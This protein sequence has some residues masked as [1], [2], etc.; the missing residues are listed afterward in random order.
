MRYLFS[1]IVF[2]A[3]LMAGHGQQL[4]GEYSLP[5]TNGQITLT[6]QGTQNITGT[7]VDDNGA[8]YQ[9]QGTESQGK[10]TGG[11]A[12]PQGGLIYFE[13]SLQGNQLNFTIV[14]LNQY[15]QP[16]YEQAQQF[17][18]NRKTPATPASPVTSGSSQS[19]LGGPLGG[20]N[21]SNG[22]AWAGTYQGNINGTASVL[23]VEQSASGIGGKINAAGYLYQFE[24]NVS[25]NQSQGILT[26][27]QTGARMDYTA[28]LTGQKIDFRMIA[29]DMYGNASNIDLSFT[30]G[31][32]QTANPQSMSS[33]N[34]VSAEDHD[35]RIIGVW[36]HTETMISG[37]F[38][39]VS[40]VFMRINPNGTYS[41]GNGRVMAGGEN[42][43][44]SVHGDTGQ[45]DDVTTGKWKTQN[46][47]IY[48]MEDGSGQWYPYSGYYIEGGTLMLKFNDGSK[49]LWYRQ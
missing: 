23:T 42:D 21:T 15:Q 16:I 48:V 22:G 9:I 6:L 5:T 26:D 8:T 29:K 10:A 3:I 41:Y 1:S 17:T 14:P 24:G 18:L 19:G 39:S 4:Q 28:A 11:L 25:G 45:S 30:K 44:G 38:S 33:Q 12:T 36:R 37:N 40:Q 43:Y 46:G 20:G 27:P 32:N 47:V 49:Q 34:Q 13:A 35:Q 2:M 31:G 7:L